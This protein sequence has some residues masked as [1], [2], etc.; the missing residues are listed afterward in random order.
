MDIK[1]YIVR[2]QPLVGFSSARERVPSHLPDLSDRVPELKGHGVG[3]GRVL[4]SRH[5]P[6]WV[7]GN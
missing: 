2:T 3:V 1:S 7:C 5:T 4:Q 6:I